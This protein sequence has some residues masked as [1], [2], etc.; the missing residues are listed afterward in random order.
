MSLRA[1]IVGSG[2]GAAGVLSQIP[3]N[4]SVDV[5]DMASQS[6]PPMWGLWQLTS[7]KLFSE[8]TVV[9]YV[10][11][12]ELAGRE[13]PFFESQLRGGAT[14][15]NGCV[16]SIGNVAAWNK[17][18]QERTNLGSYDD[19]LTRILEEITHNYP[20]KPLSNRKIDEI[21]LAASMAT[22]PGLRRGNTLFSDLQTCGPLWVKGTRWL[23]SYNHRLYKFRQANTKF[24]NAKLN[25]L[26]KYNGK[27]RL[28]L[29]D[30]SVADYDLVILAAGVIGSHKIL[31][32]SFPDIYTEP[33]LIRDH[34]NLRIKVDT[35]FNFGSLNVAEK[36]FWP[37][38]KLIWEYLRNDGSL[39]SSPG[40][41]S[42]FYVDLTGD[43]TI[44]AKIQLLNFSES[45]R[46]GS[47]GGDLFSDSPGFSIAI[48]LINQG[49]QCSYAPG[50][51][52]SHQKIEMQ[53]DDN[54]I[55]LYQKAVS[56]VFEIL[57]QEP[58]GDYVARL[59]QLFDFNYDSENFITNNIYSGYHL[60]GGHTVGEECLLRS[61]FSWNQE[62]NLFVVDAS[63][64][65]RF[66][67][68]NIEIPTTALASAWAK[69][70]LGEILG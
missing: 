66:V 14:S 18:L 3:P 41:T 57:R 4:V 33:R 61:D 30:S 63:C 31:A 22:V 56:L 49:V 12:Y 26:R 20:L 47:A 17:F 40:A 10:P 65:D 67:A 15:I 43:R 52:D 48:T 6:R 62:R 27:W 1:V 54:T 51:L 38:V 21:F 53:L 36:S 29:N 8:P 35:K 9:K 42:C 25:G 64:F 11:D 44:D 50:K 28:Q 24:I 39:L 13:I 59:P 68:S 55:R 69:K 5:I 37:K 2:A 19:S 58:L 60:I 16:A 46:L 7:M 70:N 34:P 45:G 23:R 32:N